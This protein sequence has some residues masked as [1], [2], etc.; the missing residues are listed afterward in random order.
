[1]KTLQT[2]KTF[3]SALTPVEMNAVKG[4]RYF[5]RN[6]YQVGTDTVF[7]ME[8]DFGD[9]TGSSTTITNGDGDIVYSQ[10]SRD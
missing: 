7:V 4:G 1:M 5:S 10:N 9:S 2:F 6:S 8:W 3:N